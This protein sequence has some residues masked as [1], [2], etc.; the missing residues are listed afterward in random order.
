MLILGV[1]VDVLLLHFMICHSQ[2]C[3]GSAPQ[4]VT[5]MCCCSRCVTAGKEQHG[6][7]HFKHSFFW[8]QLLL[9]PVEGQ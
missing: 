7:T 6:T 1:K 3:I 5:K 4:A 8:M 2:K 9:Y